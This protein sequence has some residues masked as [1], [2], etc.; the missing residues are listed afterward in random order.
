VEA[1]GHL[2]HLFEQMLSVQPTAE[3]KASHEHEGSIG[4]NLKLAAQN[5]AVLLLNRHTA[6]VAAILLPALAQQI[7]GH[8]F[9]G[10]KCVEHIV[11]HV[12]IHAEAAIH[13]P[14][15]CHGYSG[16]WWL[17]WQWP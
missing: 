13:M 4:N 2:L 16:R 9:G 14:N 3:A 1:V 17:G 6:G 7:L 12:L 11:R 10:T 15:S 5:A 8:R